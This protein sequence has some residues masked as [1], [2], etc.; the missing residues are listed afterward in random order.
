MT[1][2]E[3]IAE[4]TETLVNLE[5]NDLTKNLA[6]PFVL[7]QDELLASLSQEN[8]LL[9][10]IA[11]AEARARRIDAQ[12]D[13]LVDAVKYALLAIT[14]GSTTHDD[15]THYFK[16]KQ[17]AEV[18]AP[19]LGEELSFVG[20]WLPSLSASKHESL[21]EI[22]VKL[23]PLLAAGV[24]AMTAMTE[25]NQALVDFYEIGARYAL[26]EKMNSQ[27]KA[28]HGQLGQIVHDN[29]GIGLSTSFPDTFF[30]H[31][32]RRRKK[33]TPASIEAEIDA[34]KKKIASL[35]IKRDK[36]AEMVAAEQKAT[37]KKNSERRAKEI[38]KAQK[39]QAE[40]AAKLAALQ[41][42]DAGDGE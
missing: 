3:L 14:E 9:L 6:A 1:G 8:Q 20:A 16:N 13:A 36:L 37:K 40:A 18:K 7:L 38:E 24:P 29:P 15:Y 17:P 27:R 5:A 34:L 21:K 42:E 39:A 28:T 22:G 12:I 33:D 32:T 11:R 2:P 10:A 23:A 26:V 30:L 41:A 25:A 4:N 31:D 19:L 35:E